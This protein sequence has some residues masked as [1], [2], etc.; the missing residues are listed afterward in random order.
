MILNQCDVRKYKINCMK[1]I[2]TETI[3]RCRYIEI[4]NVCQFLYLQVYEFKIIRYNDI[5]SVMY[6]NITQRFSCA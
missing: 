1:N 5:F 3:T 2:L 4:K 6:M